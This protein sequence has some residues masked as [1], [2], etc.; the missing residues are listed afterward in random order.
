MK[1]FCILQLPVPYGVSLI[2]VTITRHVF[3]NIFQTEYFSAVKYCH[4]LWEKYELSCDTKISKSLKKVEK[5]ELGSFK[6]NVNYNITIAICWSLYILVQI[7]NVSCKSNELHDVYIYWGFPKS[8]IIVDTKFFL[9][10]IVVYIAIEPNVLW[11][12]WYNLEKN[13]CY[14]CDNCMM[15][16]SKLN[17]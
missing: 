5:I 12:K 6:S 8:I 4:G 1:Q 7:W 2:I 10:M 3:I 16:T 15:C 14:K 17:L 11:I 13:R 9:R